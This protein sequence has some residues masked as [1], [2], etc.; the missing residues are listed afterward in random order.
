MSR[1]LAAVSIKLNLVE[2]LQGAADPTA[3]GGVAA[4]IGSWYQR[5]GIGA[6]YLKT[7]AANTGWAKMVQSFEWL[8]VLDFGAI[9]NGVTDD[10]AAI[11]NAINA[12]AAQGGG[13]VYFP[14]LTYAVTQ[15]TI[16]AQSNVQ[17]LGAGSGSILKWVWNAAGAA[18]SMVTVNGASL[19]TRFSM[20]HFDGSG[21][22]NP[23]AGRD[24]HLLLWSGSTG[25]IIET[26][27]FQCTFGGMIASSG[28]GI[29]VVGTAGNVVSRWWVADC[30]FD[31]CSRFSVGI[32]QGLEFGWIVDN[33]MTNCETEIGLVSDA[34]VND[35]N[36]LTIA[37][38]EI[39]H[40]GAVRHAMRIE[41]D[42]TNVVTRLVIAE[43]VI[44]GGFVTYQNVQWG[45]VHGNI[46]TSGAFASADPVWRLLGNVLDVTITGN[47]IDRA[48]GASAGVVM[49]LELAT[50]APARVRVGHNMLIQEVASAGFMKVIDCNHVSIG[51]NLMRS[52]A[53]IGASAIYGVDIQ[54]VTAIVTGILFGPG[55]QMT[56][57]AGS[58]AGGVHTLCNGNNITNI[59][60]SG[61]QG[62]QLDYGLVIE[63]GGGGGTYNGIYLYGGNNM[64]GSVGDINRIGTTLP[65]RIGFNAGTF[66]PNLWSASGSPET[67]VTARAGSIY[68]NTAGGQ[69]ATL[70]YK[71]SGVAATG[72]FGVGGD[73]LEWGTGDTTAAATAVFMGA[74]FIA[75]SPATEIQLPVTRPGTIRNLRVFVPTAGVG[76]QTVTYKVRVNGVDTAILATISNTS[77]GQISDLTHSVV[78][79]AGDLISISI[80]KAAGV[81][82]GQ[83][84]VACGLEL[85]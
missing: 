54:A 9:G 53:N 42:I 25:T 35:N 74:G 11:Q 64:N 33:F 20:M 34:S 69:A 8:S 29:H 14:A 60:I 55:N 23:N 16:N 48:A 15:L 56:A 17:F 2:I 80:T 61:N 84:N 32:Q 62:N 43:N 22:T 5:S 27:A 28:D 52:T 73:V 21:L 58:M 39:V 67:V 68:L 46:V 77:T 57:A 3:G 36:A 47:L 19:H 26:Q 31:G 59:S 63:I 75:T 12:C 38:N 40:T 6:T 83:L 72:W 18:G 41:G 13:V 4:A 7:A 30:E 50:S 10:T 82:S 78:V 70:F 1:E 66:G 45:T 85:V 65:I 37:G 76:A 24:N 44:L 81:T 51:G 71:E 49:S 79:A